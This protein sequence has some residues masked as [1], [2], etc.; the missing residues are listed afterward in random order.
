MDQWPKVQFDVRTSAEVSDRKETDAFPPAATFT[1]LYLTSNGSLDASPGSGD[2]FVSF[3]HRKHGSVLTF[4]HKFDKRTE[5][6][7]YSSVKL[8]IQALRY[9]DADLFVALQK[10]DR[11]GKEVR[12]YHSTQQIEASAS[13]GWLRVSHRELDATRSRPERPYHS[14]RKRQWLRPSDIVE[15]DVEVWPSS[16]IWEQGETLRLAVKGSPFTDTENLTQV[17]GPSHGFGE[18]RVWVGSHESS[19]LVPIAG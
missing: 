15:V 8:F 10:I 2:E 16:T 14:H 4:D 6:T 9:P 18:V 17:K 13:F 11:D 3:D 12:F 19:L 5:I 7:G 1:R